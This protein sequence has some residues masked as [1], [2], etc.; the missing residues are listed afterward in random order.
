MQAIPEAMCKIFPVLFSK[1]HDYPHKVQLFMQASAAAL[2]QFLA[3]E[4]KDD[5]GEHIL[6]LSLNTNWGAL[7]EK[8]FEDTVSDIASILNLSTQLQEHLLIILKGFKNV[9]KGLD[10]A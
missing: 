1:T 6:E 7:N 4:I 2:A 8:E 9:G 5:N 10:L 3:H